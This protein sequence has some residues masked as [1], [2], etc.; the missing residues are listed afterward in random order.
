[1]HQHGLECLLHPTDAHSSQNCVAH[2]TQLIPCD[3]PNQPFLFFFRSFDLFPLPVSTL[4]SNFSFVLGQKTTM[5][6]GIHQPDNK[7]K[8]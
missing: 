4:Y 1:M 5:I 2:R 3:G 8:G 6:R 7:G